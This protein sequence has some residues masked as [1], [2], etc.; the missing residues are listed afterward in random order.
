MTV[1]VA[2]IRAGYRRPMLERDLR[3]QKKLVVTRGKVSNY[4]GFDG[5]L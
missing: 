4:E 5:T 3:N 1:Q 2:K